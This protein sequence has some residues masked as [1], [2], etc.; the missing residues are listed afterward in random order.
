MEAVQVIPHAEDLTTRI[1][2]VQDGI[3]RIA[4]FVPVYNI[5]FNQFLL[6][7]EKPTL[8]HTGPARLYNAVEKRVKEVIDL[9]KLRYVI[10]LHFE[11]D[12]W[13]GMRFLESPSAQLVCSTLSPVLNLQGW[14]EAPKEHVGV[15]EGDTIS[16]GKKQLRFLMTPH[17][18][19]WDSMMVFEETQKALFP[20]DLFLQQGD[21]SPVMND[22]SLTQGMIE[23]YK[24]VGIFAHEKPVRDVLPKLERLH[25]RMIHAMHGSSLDSSVHKDFFQALRREDFGYNNYLL[26]TKVPD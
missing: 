25:S 19:H 9:E 2:E 1:D 17:V 12:E 15:W 5:T 23:Q 11:S 4:T 24:S 13:G 14:Y 20:S 22:P 3:Y 8:V 21:N 18:H 10:F 16:L 6:K 7:D 26:Y